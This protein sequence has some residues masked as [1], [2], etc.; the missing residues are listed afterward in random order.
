MLFCLPSSFNMTLV[1]HQSDQLLFIGGN[2]LHIKTKHHYQVSSYHTTLIRWMLKMFGNNICNWSEP[3][4]ESFRIG[5]GSVVVKNRAIKVSISI[6]RCQVL[7]GFKFITC[8]FHVFILLVFVSIIYLSLILMFAFLHWK[9]FHKKEL[10]TRMKIL[11][12][13]FVI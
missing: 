8:L 9:S 3:K 11:F 1:S 10:Y 5:C 7:G 12:F 4:K 13:L 6:L 2:L